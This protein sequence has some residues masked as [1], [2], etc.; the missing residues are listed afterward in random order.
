MIQDSR[1]RPDLGF[2]NRTIKTLQK[3]EGFVKPDTYFLMVGVAMFG[4]AT[5][6]CSII[7]EF[8]QLPLE[9]IKKATAEARILVRGRAI[10]IPFIPSEVCLER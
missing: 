1:I 3:M 6:F 10:Q 7:F 4:L 8:F 2:K 9:Y 5:T